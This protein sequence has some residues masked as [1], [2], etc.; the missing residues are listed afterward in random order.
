M[1]TNFVVSYRGFAITAFMVFAAWAP[2]ISAATFKVGSGPN[3]THSTVA[4]AVAATEGSAGPDTVRVTRSAAYTQQ[5]ISFSV[6]QEVTITGGFADCITNVED[7]NYTTLSGS[8][9]TTA[10][11]MTISGSVGSIIHLRKLTITGGDLA[12]LGSLGGGIYYTGDG[13]LDIADSS[14]SNNT[15]AYGGGINVNGTSPAAGLNIGPDTTISGNTA[16]Y[17]GGGLFSN[18]IETVIRGDGILITDNY[19]LG[20]TSGGNTSGGS[21]GGILVRACALDSIVYLGSPGSLGLP[22]VYN[23]DARY[24]G[25]VSV[26]GDACSDAKSAELRMFST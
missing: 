9:V 24:G 25:G 20:V 12:S 19:A 14:I 11:V 4:A 8:G 5:A 6:T 13:L 15:A 16:L 7:A 3:C 26:E 10:T 18:N 21:G 22:V 23:N 1:G 2:A 17:N